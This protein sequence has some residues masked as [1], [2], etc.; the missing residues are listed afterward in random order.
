MRPFRDTLLSI[1]AGSAALSCGGSVTEQPTVSTA[2]LSSDDAAGPFKN[3]SGASANLSTTGSIDTTNAFFQSLG[4]NGRACVSCHAP[5]D[6]FSITPGSLQDLFDKCGL[7]DDKPKKNMSA[8]LQLACAIFRTNDGSNSPNADVST[9]DARRS[10][11][12]LLLSKGLIRFTFPVPSNAMFDVVAANDPYGFGTTAAPSVFRRPLPATNLLFG[13]SVMWDLRESSTKFLVA[14]FTPDV[15]HV[16][17]LNDQLKSQALH[18][19]LGHAQAM[20]PGLT[21][22]QQQSIVNF[23]LALFSA[24]TRV[25]GAGLLSKLGAMGGPQALSQQAV[26]PVCGNLVVVDNNPQ[27]PQCQQ[28]TFTPIVFTIFDAWANLQG[29]GDKSEMRASIARGQTLFDTRKTQSPAGPFFDHSGDNNNT[30]CS[31]CHS[32]FNAGAPSVPIGFQNV[33]IG[34]GPN[35][36]NTPGFPTDFTSPDLPVYTL[37]CNKHGMDVFKA[38]KGAA[39]CHDGTEPGIPRDEVKTN[40]PGRG[41]ITGSWGSVS[42]FKCPTLRNLSAHAPYFHD[43]SSATLSDVVDHYKAALGFQFTDDEKQDLVNFLSAL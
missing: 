14:P 3:P 9:P 28:Y 25:E 34:L 7:S 6:G 23:E 26:T 2:A 27:F 10:A 42:A 12:N 4:T 24:Q 21:D 20:A 19:T 41:L 37:Q 32:D 35:S 18:A 36:F 29:N 16:P 22:A 30:T 40:D 13:S 1:L 38:S 39:G 11:Y 15:T 5:K 43:G 8:D 17:S 33:V 31:T